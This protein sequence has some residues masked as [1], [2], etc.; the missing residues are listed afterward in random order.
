MQRHQRRGA[1]G[2]HGDRRP[3]QP[4]EVGDPSR[5]DTAG[6]P[7]HQVGFQPVRYRRDPRGVVVLHRADVHAGERAAQGRGVDAGPLDRLPGDLQQQALLRVH[8]HRL[9]RRHPEHGRVE[10]GRVVE[11]RAVSRVAPARLVRIGIVEFGEVPAAIGG[12]SR[13][14]VPPFGHQLPQVL[15]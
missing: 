7:R 4:E 12:K 2:V 9:T 8:G 6:V 3:L 10:L 5:R 13:D 14:G 1:R 11:E 15:G